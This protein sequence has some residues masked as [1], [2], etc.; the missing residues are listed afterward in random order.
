MA[1]LEV[2]DAQFNNEILQH[3]IAEFIVFYSVVHPASRILQ[4]VIEELSTEFGD[5]LK[6]V[7]IDSFE[8]PEW[9][10]KYK[11]RTIPTIVL[12]RNGTE[13][14]RLIGFPIGDQNKL[15]LKTWIESNL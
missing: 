13:V 15:R 6:F 14:A 4:P 11:V 8:N 5:Q 9:G 3:P 2:T 10:L 7:K 1:V 12:L